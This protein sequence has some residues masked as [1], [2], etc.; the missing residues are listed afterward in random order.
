[1]SRRFIALRS[2]PATAIDQP[3]VVHVFPVSPGF[4]TCSLAIDREWAVICASWNDARDLARH[5]VCRGSLTIKP[6]LMDY[7]QR[8]VPD[9]FHSLVE[10]DLYPHPYMAGCLINHLD[11][12]IG[13]V[14]FIR[15]PRRR[16]AVA[17][18]PD[19]TA[20][21]EWVNGWWK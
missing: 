11:A 2:V 16:S 14:S 4:E 7:L 20:R 6:E 15:C 8:R 13:P 3:C 1:M 21:A 18:T 12:E 19:G 5:L 10:M 9:P 17:R